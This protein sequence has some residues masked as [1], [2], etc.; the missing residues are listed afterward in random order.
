[1]IKYY[2][3][4]FQKNKIEIT[5][6]CNENFCKYFMDCWKYSNISVDIEFFIR[7]LYYQDIVW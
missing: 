5:Y 3:N 1:M 2:R 7:I 4:I 6:F